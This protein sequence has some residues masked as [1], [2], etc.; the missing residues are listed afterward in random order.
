MKSRRELPLD[1]YFHVKRLN[2]WWR[3]EARRGDVLVAG[4]KLRTNAYDSRYALLE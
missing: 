2:K 4:S 1:H 3:S